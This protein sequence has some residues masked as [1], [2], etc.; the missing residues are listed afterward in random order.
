MACRQQAACEVTFDSLSIW[1][2][3]LHT[4]PLASQKMAEIASTSPELA[5]N[6]CEIPHHAPPRIGK[7]SFLDIR[8]DLARLLLEA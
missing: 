2:K 5:P 8:H 6:L 1:Q 4:P 7:S 3:G